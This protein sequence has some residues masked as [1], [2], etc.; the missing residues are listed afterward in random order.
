M[1]DVDTP[2]TI[3]VAIEEHCENVATAH[4]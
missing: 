1:H 3:D 2:P 4:I